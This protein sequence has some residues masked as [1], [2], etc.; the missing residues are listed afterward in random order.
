MK[1]II[2]LIAGCMA[3]PTAALAA[4]ELIPVTPSGQGKAII[5]AIWVLIIF[6][7][8]LAIL[9]PTAW[10]AVLNGLKNREQRIRREIADAEAARAHAEETL[11]KYTKQLAEAEERIREMLA[12]SQADGERHVASIRDNAMKEADNM[13][14]KALYD[15]QEAKKKVI[16][17]IHQEAVELST[18]IAEKIIRRN[19]SSED[20]RQFVRVSIEQLEASRRN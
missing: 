11:A 3:F 10:K 16:E 18:A 6:S 5:Q 17:D 8:V 2:L 9:Y 7:I 1:H 19:L 15:I 13:R 12:K 4:G 20:Q 14:N